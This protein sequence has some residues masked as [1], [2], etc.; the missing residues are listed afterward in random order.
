VAKS[1]S[2]NTRNVEIGGGT[3]ELSKLLK[4]AGLTGS[5]G[6]AKHAIREGHVLLNGVVET[7]KGKQLVAGDR[8]SF[9]GETVVLV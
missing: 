8:I 7:R 1:S 5:G 9:A 6:E 2:E 3:I 4:F